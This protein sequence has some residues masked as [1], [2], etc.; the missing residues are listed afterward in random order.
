M[1]I[2]FV[3]IVPYRDRIE[4]KNF[5]DIYMNY[6]LE[7]ISDNKYEI[8]FSHQANDLPF[9][10][11]AMK[12]IGFLY[13]KEKYPEY[14]K[15][16]NFI[17]N[18]IDTLPYKKNLLNYETEKGEIKHYYGFNFALGGIFSIKGED[19]E[20]INGFP[21]YWNWG[22]EDNVIYQRALYNKLK[23]NRDI[24]FEINNRNIL[25]FAD[26][27]LKSI[28]YNILLKQYDDKKQKKIEKDGLNYIKNIKYSYENNMLNVTNFETIY[29]FN[30]KIY[31]HDSKKNG[32]I[33]M[34]PNSASYKKPSLKMNIQTNRNNNINNNRK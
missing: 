21:N 5:F 34:N 14:Y 16:I 33:I 25:H 18:D 32:G 27:H 26:N 7:D 12:N 13:I 22:F 24:F 30:N 3:F 15:N 4:H 31:I 9:N 19:F 10:R 17:F 11:G 2:S 1:D 20:K 23:I 28:D 6:L 8:I 29:K